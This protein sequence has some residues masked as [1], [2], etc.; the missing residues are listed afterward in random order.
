MAGT[1]S[2]FQ[3]HLRGVYD[4]KIA[5][6]AEMPNLWKDIVGE[7]ISTNAL[8]EKRVLM[9]GLAA[10]QRTAEDGTFPIDTIIAPYNKTFVTEVFGVAVEFTDKQLGTDQHGI[11]RR[12]GQEFAVSEAYAVEDLVADLLNN[13]VDTAYPTI[14]GGSNPIA[15]ATQPTT[16]GATWS[17]VST[18]AALS[19]D[20]LEQM[21]TDRK[22]HRDLKNQ[23]WL[24]YGQW[25]LVTPI[26][27]EITAH[28][29]LESIGQP[30]TADNDKNVVRS[31]ITRT[32]GNPF[33]TDT[34]CF[35]AIPT[36]E[37]PLFLVNNT[38][39]PEDTIKEHERPGT[40]IKVMLSAMDKTTGC[41]YPAGVQRN[42]GA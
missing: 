35:W 41:M 4:V 20:S 30:G 14:L 7:T 11:L 3:L 36:D 37:N 16:T 38:W 10:M 13:G 40:L 29:L 42:A 25:K 9:T 19:I 15:S 12:F 31:T 17:N 24:K 22:A 34:N 28:R 6:T 1:G 21:A 32:R 27:L 5:R 2:T 39:L 26:E 33:I 18:A 23:R 8:G